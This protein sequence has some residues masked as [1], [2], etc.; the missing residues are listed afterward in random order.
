MPFV[1]VHCDEGHLPHLRQL[2]D[3]LPQIVAD[4]FNDFD[5]ERVLV[6]Q[7]VDVEVKE[8]GPFDRVVAPVRII[9]VGRA[10]ATLERSLNHHIV[11]IAERIFDMFPHWR[12]KKVLAVCVMPVNAAY[13]HF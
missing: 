7:N 2:V 11:A 1:H 5:G 8:V 6:E 13:T 10:N 3:A 4:T 12:G 9:V